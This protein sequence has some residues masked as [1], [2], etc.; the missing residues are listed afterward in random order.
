MAG[1]MRMQLDFEKIKEIAQGA[2]RI[3]ESGGEISFFRFSKAEDE[4]YSSSELYPRTFSTAGVKLDFKTDATAIS[5]KVK[6]EKLTNISL[7]AFDIYADKEQIGCIKN[8]PDDIPETEYSENDYPTGNFEGRFELPSGGEKEIEI[9][10]PWSLKGSLISL[11]LENASY[12]DVVRRDKKILVYGDSIVQGTAAKNPSC[13]HVVKLAD[14]LGAELISKAIGSEVYFPELAEQKAENYSPDY[15]YVG[16]GVND[17]YTLAYDDAEQRCRRF[18]K[19]IC[20]NYPN[21]KKICVSPIWYRDHNVDRK[22]GPL[23]GAEDIQRR[24][25]QEY[26]D[27]TF[28]KG[29]ELVPHG[30]E[31]LVDGVHPNNAGF[32]IFYNN[33]KT[34][35][36]I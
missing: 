1:E 15:I 25:T 30:G 13:A 27:V 11:E 12:A 24:V 36:S 33:L 3:V 6:A 35:L 8:Y 22:F 20:K 23:S 5:I 19:A 4:V 31:Y 34:E 2:E 16:Y 14:Y 10:F 28:V 18:W 7:F 21:S 29:W 26:P 9:Y 32:E 17:W